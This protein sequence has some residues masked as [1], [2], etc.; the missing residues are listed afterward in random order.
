MIFFGVKFSYFVRL[1]ISPALNLPKWIIFSIIPVSGLI[2]M[3]HGATFLLGEI[4][5]RDHDN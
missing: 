5:R 2:F 3:V 1:Q 4:Q